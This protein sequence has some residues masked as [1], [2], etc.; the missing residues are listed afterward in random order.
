MRLHAVAAVPDRAH[1]VD[2]RA[3]RQIAGNSNYRMPGRAFALL[4]QHLLASRQQR[5]TGRSVDGP[6]YSATTQQ[7][8][9]CRINNHIDIKCRNIAENYLRFNSH[10]SSCRHSVW[11]RLSADTRAF[12]PAG[13]RLSLCP[14][15]RR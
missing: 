9:I 11:I 8:G 12:S 14:V 13:A 6:V 15:T 7:R 3:G 10:F 4:L 1:G 5:G 2:H